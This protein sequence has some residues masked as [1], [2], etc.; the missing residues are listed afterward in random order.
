MTG[1]IPLTARG[2][3]YAPGVFQ[4]SAGV[5]ALPGYRIE[6]VRFAR[7]VPM[8]DGW[9]RIA[10]YLTAQGLPTTAFCACELRSPA[11]FTEAG[12]LSFNRDYAAVLQGWGVLTEQGPPRCL[13]WV[14]TTQSGLPQVFLCSVGRRFSVP[15]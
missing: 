3:A 8:A 5:A 14:V 7:V 12:F 4:Y 2:Y 13:E 6:R 15:A 10:A 11:P 1:A 9:A